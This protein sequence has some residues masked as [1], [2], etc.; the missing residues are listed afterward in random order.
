[1]AWR[2]YYITTSDGNT[3]PDDLIPRSAPC[4]TSPTI[5]ETFSRNFLKKISPKHLARVDDAIAM[6]QAGR[7]NDEIVEKHGRIVL[8]EAIKAA[9]L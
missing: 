9:T 2:N 5:G 7:T 6:L 1:M 8:R 3:C 4:G